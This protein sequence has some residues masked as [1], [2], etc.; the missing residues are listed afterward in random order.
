MNCPNCG[1][2]NNEGT[3]FCTKCGFNIGSL[4][5]QASVSPVT[6]ES[7]ISG[8]DVNSQ[9]NIQENNNFSQ[10]NDIVVTDI[11][12]NNVEQNINNSM[13][14]NN[15]VN[16]NEAVTGVD[17]KKTKNKK[18]IFIIIGVVV[19]LAVVIVLIFIFT[20]KGNLSDEAGLDYIFNPS[21]PIPVLKDGKYGY[22]S[23]SGE[24][25]LEPKYN[26]VGDFYD[27][28]AVVSI[29]NPDTTAN[30]KSIYSII[31]KNGNR[32]NNYEIYDKPVYYPESK[33][34]IIESELYDSKINKISSDGVE[35]SYLGNGYLV[36]RNDELDTSGIM[37]REGKVTYTYTPDTDGYVYVMYD[38]SENE[39]LFEED[40]CRV[41]VSNDVYAIINCATGDI[42]YDFTEYYISAYDNNIFKISDHDTFDT[43]MRIYVYNNKILYQ[44]KNS[45][46][47]IKYDSDG[48]IKIKDGDTKY[49]EVKT[50]KILNEK[51][52]IGDYDIDEL[53]LLDESIYGF[54]ITGTY[55][56]YGLVS[57]NKEIL[58]SEFD[59]IDF[60]GS[61]L[62]N[63]VKKE[64]GQELILAEK[65]G[66]TLLMN[67]KNQKV[68]TSFDSTTID[69]Y[70]ES[71]FLKISLY[72]DN[73]YSRTGYLIYNV[74]SGKSM[75]FD[76][77]NKITIESN[78]ITVEKDDEVVYYNTELEQI[79]KEGVRNG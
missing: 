56:S 18:L 32:V 4:N 19:L 66:K 43:I 79:Y 41:N 65:D 39:D 50:G 64:S 27:G 45:D 31:D 52:Y 40:Y 38:I 28:Y 10:N 36:W 71:S 1:N 54:R 77:E 78:Y 68:I 58:S 67:V 70:D 20:G 33:T 62:F 9:V 47:E 60:L 16:N 42:V 24:V 37:N 34:W 21:N 17:N 30:N 74:L 25:L 6:S 14:I 53:D 48:Y 23:N 3:N 55:G 44:T 15:V 63:Y 29:D 57:K 73:K 22:I 35:V 2:F 5:S 26:S 12:S 72:E 8:M 61:D 59:D 11:L 7:V 13:P 46:G 51:P 69:Y 75:K 49:I 76:T